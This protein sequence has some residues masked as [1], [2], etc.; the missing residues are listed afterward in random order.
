EKRVY[1]LSLVRQT[2]RADLNM[3]G[4]RSHPHIANRKGAGEAVSRGCRALEG[5]FADFEQLM[6]HVNIFTPEQSLKTY[7]CTF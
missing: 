7:Y 5:L 6:V 4:S 2:K 1:T 3:G